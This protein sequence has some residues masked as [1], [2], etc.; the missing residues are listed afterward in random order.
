MRGEDFDDDATPQE[1][2]EPPLPTPRRG[3]SKGLRL[4]NAATKL[5]SERR[6]TSIFSAVVAGLQTW[7]IRRAVAEMQI[8]ERRAREKARAVAVQQGA[9][10]ADYE[11]MLDV[12]FVW[13]DTEIPERTFE[14]YLRKARNLLDDQHSEL[15]GQRSRCL[16]KQ[17]ARLDAMYARASRDGKL[18]AALKAIELQVDLFGLRDLARQQALQASTSTADAPE[19]RLPTTPEARAAAFADLMA[20]SMAAATPELRAQL[21]TLTHRPVMP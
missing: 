2:M 21:D 9:A 12:P 3:N 15:A 5:V 11:A 14:L 6:V 1:V 16:A 8:K 10:D 4:R 20:R 18:Y 13:G 19:T 7:E 17:V